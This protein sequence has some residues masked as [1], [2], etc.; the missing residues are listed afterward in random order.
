MCPVV[1][2]GIPSHANHPDDTLPTRQTLLARLKNWQDQQSWQ[3]FFDT[4][5]RLIY[6]VAVQAGLSDAEAQ[7]VVQETVLSVARAMGE[8]RVGSAYGSFKS[9]LLQIMRRR[10]ADQFRKRDPHLWK[11]ATSAD[12][13]PHTATIERVPDPMSLVGDEVWDEQWR[14]NLGEIALTRVKQRTS[15]KQWLLFQHFVLME[16]PAREVALK[17]RVSL[18]QVYM[19]KYRLAAQIKKEVRRL[20]RKMK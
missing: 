17:C 13:T 16:L 1:I 20:E 4:Y 9:W 3:E 7:E 6:G 19:A 14:R 10:I 18:A 8:F 15:P 11:L 5:W 12:D 2:T